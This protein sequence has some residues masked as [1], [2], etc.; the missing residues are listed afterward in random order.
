MKAAKPA[1]LGVR[2]REEGVRAREEENKREEREG[3]V[4]EGCRPGYNSSLFYNFK[5]HVTFNKSHIKI[6]TFFRVL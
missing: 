2:E 4:A 1:E 3:D 6:R 5:Y